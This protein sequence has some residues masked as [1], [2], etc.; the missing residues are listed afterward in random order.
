[1]GGFQVAN[2]VSKRIEN[3]S[4]YVIRT[5]DVTCGVGYYKG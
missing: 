4:A 3:K 1:M 2:P 5:H